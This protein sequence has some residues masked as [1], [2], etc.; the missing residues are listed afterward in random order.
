MT[1]DTTVARLPHSIVTDRHKGDAVALIAT[2]K[3]GEDG[4]PEKASFWHRDCIRDS[5]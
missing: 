1:R 3:Q 5:R 2:A 4:T